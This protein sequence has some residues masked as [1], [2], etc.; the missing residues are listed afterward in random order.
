MKKVLILFLFFVLPTFAW[1][2]KK[3]I[4]SSVAFAD[5][6]GYTLSNGTLIPTLSAP[7]ILSGDGQFVPTSV[8]INPISAG[9]VLAGFQMYTNNQMAPTGTT[10]I[11]RN[12]NS[13]GLLVS[14][15]CARAGWILSGASPIDL[16]QIFCV[17]TPDPVFGQAVL[18]NPVATQTILG[19]GLVLGAGAHLTAGKINAL[20]TVDGMQNTTLAAA[21]NCAGTSGTIEVPPPAGTLAVSS[22]ATIPS[23]V[24]LRIDQ[25]A[26]LAPA[27]GVT[28]TVNGPIVAGNYNIFCPKGTGTILVNSPQAIVDVWFPGAE[29]G[30]QINAAIA[31]LPTLGSHPIGTLMLSVNGLTTGVSLRTQVNVDP[32]YLSIVGPGQHTLRLVCSVAVCFNFALNGTWDPGLSNGTTQG[33]ISGFTL[34][35][36]GSSNQVGFQCSG[37]NGVAW[38]DISITNFSGTGAVGW[39]WSN[40]PNQFS[41]RAFIEK[42]TLD[43]NT[44]NLE[45]QDLNSNTGGSGDYDYWTVLDLSMNINAGTTGYDIENDAHNNVSFWRIKF[46]TG[47]GSG[48]TAFLINGSSTFSGNQLF[49]HGDDSGQA[50]PYT[51]FNVASGA[52]AVGN[53]GI[54]GKFYNTTRWPNSISGTFDFHGQM[55]STSPGINTQHAAFVETTGTP[56]TS[57]TSQS[58][59]LHYLCGQ[60]WTGGTTAQDCWTIQAVEGSGTNGSSAL[61]FV[62][63]AGTTGGTLVTLGAPQIQIPSASGGTGNVNLFS[64]VTSSGLSFH[65]LNSSGTLVQT[66]QKCTASQVTETGAAT[67]L[68]CTP[69]GIAGSY[70][71]RVVISVSAANAATIGWTATWTDSKG[72]AQTPASLS[73]FQSGT[74][75][76]ALTF[77]TSAAGDYYGDAQI[78]VDSSGANIVLKITF[79][80]TSFTAKVSASVERII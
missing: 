9:V 76:P 47:T 6:Q 26:C 19:E 35:G 40:A 1:A 69:P 24:A 73:L 64:P 61:N 75:A 30:A 34:V 21:I 27:T 25:G 68:T 13:N 74:A 17:A 29:R 63:V 79:S 23:G 11:T 12:Y 22:N 72:N 49:L 32:Y 10:H 15:P 37:L 56:A 3:T 18:Q 2:G 20:C 28:L 53:S 70:R 58:S 14:T 16:S 50:G 38:R 48:G 67:V 78:D 42:V 71:L 51:L 66:Q 57:G 43:T 59:P 7:A 54:I 65:F 52:Q 46:N 60:Y 41:E 62:H 36:N 80:G 31:S 8:T 4:T 77:T 5:L 55:V 45:I 39:L 44:T 33:S